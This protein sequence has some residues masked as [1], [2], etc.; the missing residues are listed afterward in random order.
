MVSEH[1]HRSNE[2]LFCWHRGCNVLEQR[3]LRFVPVNHE[4]MRRVIGNE[5]LE[6]A[7]TKIAAPQL[8][9]VPVLDHDPL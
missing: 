6:R 1:T 8:Q 3:F 2:Q 9:A 5:F 4:L 7:V